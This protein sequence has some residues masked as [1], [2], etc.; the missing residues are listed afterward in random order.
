MWTES[1]ANR[2]CQ[3]FDKLRYVIN[4][5]GCQV[6]CEADIECVGIIY[7]HKFGL[8]KYCYVCKDDTLTYAGNEFGFYRRP[9]KLRNSCISSFIVFISLKIIQAGKFYIIRSWSIFLTFLIFSADNN[10]EYF[11]DNNYQYY[12]NTDN[13]IIDNNYDD[14][15]NNNYYDNYNSN[16]YNELE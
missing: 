10:Y 11:N 2:Y 12:N 9:G 14:D 5:E 4:Q 8:T 15:N 13:I 16:Y 7:S 1:A 6:L 3:N